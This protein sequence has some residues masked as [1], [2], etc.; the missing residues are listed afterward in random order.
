[1]AR[2]RMVMLSQPLPGRE[3]DYERWYDD[4]HIPD[5]LQVP[6][7]VA[8]QRFRIVRNV[9]GETSF[10]FCTIY[11]MEASSPDAAL[12]AMFA[13]LQSGKVRMSDSVDPVNGQGFICEEVRERVTRS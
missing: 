5:M 6:G 7:F 11:E 8:A 12:G 3:D 4:I 9:V 2:Y 13:A 10:P 1:M